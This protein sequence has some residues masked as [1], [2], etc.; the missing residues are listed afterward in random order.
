MK[1]LRPLARPAGRPSSDVKTTYT[2]AYT[3][4][5]QPPFRSQCTRV[6]CSTSP[7]HTYLRQFTEPV[8]ISAP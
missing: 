7:E 4:S 8:N 2:P 5:A 6:C 3:L 1:H